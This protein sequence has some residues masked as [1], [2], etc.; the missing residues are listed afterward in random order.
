MRVFGLTVLVTQVQICK[1]CNDMFEDA[2]AQAHLEQCA[3][4]MEC[5]R[6][7]I[8]QAHVGADLEMVQVSHHS[9]TKRC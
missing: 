8:E 6:Q 9:S 5:A 1:N 3:A 2:F 7:L 4:L